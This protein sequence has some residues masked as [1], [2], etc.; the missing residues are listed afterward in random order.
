[1][2]LEIL[3]RFEKQTGRRITQLFDWIVASGIGAVFIIG[4][5]YGG[6]QSNLIVLL[7]KDSNLYYTTDLSITLL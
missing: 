2:Q 4:M 5:I 6:P 7:S 1:M 3:S